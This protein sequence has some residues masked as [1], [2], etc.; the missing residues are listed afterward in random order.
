MIISESFSTGLFPDKLKLAKVIPIY[1]KDSTQ[2][3]NNYG[4]ISILSVFSKMF[5]KLMYTRLCK[6]L[7]DKK[8]PMSKP[9]WFQRKPLY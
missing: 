2:N 8:Y 1:K 3:C 4:P 6:F 9:V 7:D 5:E